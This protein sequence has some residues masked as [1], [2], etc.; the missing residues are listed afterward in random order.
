MRFC[1]F[2]IAIL[3]LAGPA[4]GNA[5]LIRVELGG[6]EEAGVPRSHDELIA[7]CASAGLTITWRDQPYYDA[8]FG[9]SGAWVANLEVQTTADT[10]S[11][12]WSAFDDPGAAAQ[13]ASGLG[14]MY[15]GG[16][17]LRFRIEDRWVVSA[18]AQ[19]GNADVSEWVLDALTGTL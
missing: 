8:Y 19:S 6:E 18:Y 3:I 9:S 5:E 17:Y 13:H 10:V 16:G 2:M 11:I 14:S 15:G 1:S 7:R 12:S 4:S